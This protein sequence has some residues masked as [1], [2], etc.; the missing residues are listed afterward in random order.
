MSIIDQ[1][2]ADNGLIGQLV[3]SNC[4]PTFGCAPAY[5]PQ[6]IPYSASKVTVEAVEGGYIIS[7]YFHG[8][9]DMRTVALDSEGLA[10]ILKN[11]CARF[12][13]KTK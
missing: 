7:G 9:G 8:K 3:S 2:H 12:Q 6:P 10:E 1:T 5:Y 11:W 4:I 13:A